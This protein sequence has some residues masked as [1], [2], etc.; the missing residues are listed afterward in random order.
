MH[1]FYELNDRK[2]L[3]EEYSSFI[4]EDKLSVEDMIKQVIA[5]TGEKIEIGNFANFQI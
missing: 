5:K 1:K 2:P 3:E 4:K